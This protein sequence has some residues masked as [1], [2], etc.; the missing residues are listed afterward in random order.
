M[1]V[2]QYPIHVDGGPQQVLTPR[3]VTFQITHTDYVAKVV[4]YDLGIEP[5]EVTLKAGCE[6]QLSAV[7][8]QGTPIEDF[9]IMM[10][11]PYASYDWVKSDS[12]GRRTRAINDGNWQTMLV[13]IPENGPILFSNVLPLRVRP[14]QAVRVR[15]VRLSP[16]AK[17]RGKLSKNVNPPVRGYVVAV[18]CPKPAADSYS[19]QDPSLA[20]HDWV[21]IA[22][23]GSFEFESL[24]RGGELQLIGVCDGWISSTSI[25]EAR[26]FVMGQLFNLD[27]DE[28]DIELNM[29]PTG[30]LE[31]KLVTDDGK[32]FGEGRIASWPNQKYYKGGSTLLGQ[33]YRSKHFVVNQLLPADRQSPVPELKASFPFDQ[34]VNKEGVARLT[35]LPIGKRQHFVFVHNKFQ[36]AEDAEEIDFQLDSPQPVIKTVK[37]VESKK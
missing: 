1:A 22:A 9:G 5:A 23:D 19:D 33:R 4:H 32:P 17:V 14:Q 21:E 7:D 24:P 6:V 27:R 37:V 35:G 25:P 18:S 28:L 8:D 36:L 15:N 13:K 20:W 34:T 16:G 11:G 2:I 26:S 31:L 29:E 12:G 30:T 3:L 10:A